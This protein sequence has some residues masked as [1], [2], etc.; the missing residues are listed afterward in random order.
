MVAVDR[1]DGVLFY[2]QMVATSGTPWLAC[3]PNAHGTL[4]ILPDNSLI[5]FE[6]SIL[7][8]FRSI[9]SIEL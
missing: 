4:S 6:F 3:P 5:T 8:I 9:P 1:A 2:G 7:I